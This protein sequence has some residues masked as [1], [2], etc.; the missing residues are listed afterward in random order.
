MFS[1]LAAFTEDF[2][3]TNGLSRNPDPDK[4]LADQLFGQT[5]SDQSGL[6]A[7]NFRKD[8]RLPRLNARGV[9]MTMAISRLFLLV[10]YS[11]GVLIFPATRYRA[12]MLHYSLLSCKTRSQANFVG[13]SHRATSVLL[14]VLLCSLYIARC[15]GEQ[16]R[17]TFT[18]CGNRKTRVV[19]SP[20]P[21]GNCQSFCRP[22]CTWVCQIFNGIGPCPLR[23]R[24]SNYVRRPSS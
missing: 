10:Q 3:I 24:L 12:L 17:R 6:A 22:Q 18:G 4:V 7:F 23:H 11:L 15:H 21:R 14:A 16:R 20:D 13:G 8:T 1:A 9:A 5:G 19:L 2:D